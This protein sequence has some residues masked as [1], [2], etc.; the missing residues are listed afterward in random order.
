MS[1]KKKNAHFG[2]KE[3]K[4]SVAEKN[5]KESLISKHIFSQLSRK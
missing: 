5:E 2:I 4:F 1:W 3:K